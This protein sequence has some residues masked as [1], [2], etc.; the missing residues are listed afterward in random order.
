MFI[1]KHRAFK[2]STFRLNA[3]ICIGI[4]LG[5]FGDFTV[6]LV[7]HFFL[8]NIT[9]MQVITNVSPFVSYI[10]AVHTVL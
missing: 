2:M 10:T 6:S 5:F 7:V 3:I 1:C 9:V 4:F 8:E